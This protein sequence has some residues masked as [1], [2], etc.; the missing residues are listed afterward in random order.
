VRSLSVTLEPQAFIISNR[1]TETPDPFE[2]TAILALVRNNKGGLDAA[3]KRYVG[4]RPALKYAED[5]AS[6]TIDIEN[7][8]GVYAQ[9]Y[10]TYRF[11]G[12]CAFLLEQG[13]R[14]ECMYG[15]HYGTIH[16][17]NDGCALFIGGTNAMNFYHL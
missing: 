15:A 3:L 1:G 14:S 5:M 16:L 17:V 13:I 12:L 6:K 4:A 11:K 7:D 9:M 8:T 10:R 2:N